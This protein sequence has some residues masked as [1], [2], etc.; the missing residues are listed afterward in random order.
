MSRKENDELGMIEKIMMNL[1]Q[2]F[3]NGNK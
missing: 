2:K 1:K 3:K